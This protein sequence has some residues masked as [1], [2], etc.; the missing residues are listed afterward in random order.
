M[1]QNSLRKIDSTP[2]TKEIEDSLREKLSKYCQ[3]K[4]LYCVSTRTIGYPYRAIYLNAPEAKLLLINPVVKKYG[5]NRINSQEVSEFVNKGR[6]AKTVI[7]A[8]SIEVECDNLGTV[9]FSGDTETNQKDLNECIM[10]QQ[11]IDLL[12]G[13]TIADRNINQPIIVKAEYGRNQLVL[14]KNPDG[15]IEHI[16]YKY[17]QRYIDKGYVIM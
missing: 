1:K 4:N 3:K 10:I 13:F 14:A 5:D 9:I 11:M 16:K 8:T 7:R 2:F 6:K 17:V 15:I 12:D